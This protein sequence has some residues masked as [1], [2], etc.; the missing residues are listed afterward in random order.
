PETAALTVTA[1]VRSGLAHLQALIAEYET[2]AAQPLDAAGLRALEDLQRRIDAE[3]GW[4]IDR[5]VERVL[6]DMELPADAPLASL[7]GG[8]RRRAA[9][10][11]AL[12]SN[13]ELLLLDEPTNHL[14]LATIE[15]LE[16]RIRNYAGSVLFI[17][18]D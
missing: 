7:S 9:L 3:G 6:S 15:W 11:Q 2:R 17:T 5:Q 1:F 8:W 4:D 13:P 16:K 10:A 14:D 12:V 18:H